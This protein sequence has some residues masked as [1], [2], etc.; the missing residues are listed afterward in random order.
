MQGVGR[1]VDAFMGL[2]LESEEGPLWSRCLW[3][4]VQGH[5]PWFQGGPPLESRDFSNRKSDAVTSLLR[6]GSFAV[7]VR[8]YTRMCARRCVD[9]LPLG[10]EVVPSVCSPEAVQPGDVND[11]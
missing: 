6:K 7:S 10:T 11:T 5:P 2:R 8:R 3:P 1:S 9:P 4:A